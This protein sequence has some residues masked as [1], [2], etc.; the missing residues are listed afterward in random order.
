MYDVYVEPVADLHFDGYSSS[1]Q[2]FM[3]APQGVR[4]S[5]FRN[6]VH[7]PDRAARR[8]SQQNR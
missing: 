8:S 3:H 5:S 6:I 7:R 1:A 2:N 4:R